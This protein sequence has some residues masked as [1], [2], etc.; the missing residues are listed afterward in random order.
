MAVMKGAGTLRASGVGSCIVV[1]LYDRKRRIAAMVHSLLPSAPSH[2][3]SKSLAAD[4]RYVDA[5][6]GAMLAEVSARGVTTKDIEAKIVGGASMFAKFQSNV[7]AHNVAAAHAK[8]NAEGIELAG[9]VVGGHIGRSVEF[10]VASG[11]VTTK[12]KF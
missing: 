5:A 9:E 3:N 4:A 8:L 11:L 2:N 7:G 12:T 6:I 10:C 1:T